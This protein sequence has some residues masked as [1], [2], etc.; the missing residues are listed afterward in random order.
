MTN[1]PTNKTCSHCKK[2]LP[3]NAFYKRNEGY[4][5]QCIQ[6]EQQAK[7]YKQCPRCNKSK[8]FDGELCKDCKR[9]AA[10]VY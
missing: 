2:E 3:L 1:S 4:H 8:R 5:E 10:Y 7:G 9:K 6:C